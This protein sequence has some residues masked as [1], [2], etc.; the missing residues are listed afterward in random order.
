MLK[1]LPIGA[2]S[3]LDVDQTTAHDGTAIAYYNCYQDRS[4]GIH[5]VPGLTE[6]DDV[7]TGIGSQTFNYYSSTFDTRIIVSAGRVWAQYSQSGALTEVTGGS[8]TIGVR[9][10]FCEDTNSIFVAADSLIYKITGSTMAALGGNSPDHV[11]SLLYHGGFILANGPN[12]AGDTA[13]SDDKAN[14]Y[15]LWEVYNNESKPDRLQTLVLVDS[16]FIYNLGPESCEVTFLRTNPQNPF[17]INPGR[18]SVFGTI[19]KYSPVYDGDKLRYLGKVAGKRVVIENNQGGAT[20]ISFPIDIPLED[21]ERV[22][23]AVGFMMA[24]KGQNFYCLHFPTANA[25]INE[26]FMEQVTLA[27]HIQKQAFIILSRWDAL[28][29]EWKGYRGSDFLY[30][31]PWNLRLV[32][33]SN[34]GKTFMLYDNETVD[35]TAEPAFHHRW[36]DNNSKSWNNPRTTS[37]GTAGNYKRPADK[38]QCGQYVN[39]QHEISYTD[40]TDA[41]E[42]FRMAIVS[43]NVNHQIDVTKRSNY[44]R[45]N[46]K[47]G[48]N[49][50]IIN[51]ISEDI[52]PL[53]R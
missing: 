30:I 29:G 9:P 49:E 27:Y 26:Q 33:D 37:L 40:T 22:D 38:T 25:T 1:P 24:F 19:A 6:H 45:Y 48:T 47:C 14:G 42:M 50:F 15:A 17:E 53:R 10:T 46:V 28:Q 5:R 4:A 16:Q 43:G 12:I 8:L 20:T 36:R 7:A 52:T 31:E 44:Y 11:T 41:G 3:N 39:R 13:Y 35:Y 18:I 23:D 32:G 21:F 51:T 34:S 2:G